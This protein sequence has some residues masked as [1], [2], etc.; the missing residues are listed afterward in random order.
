MFKLIYIDT[1]IIIFAITQLQFWFGVC[2]EA[3][4]GVAWLG[5]NPLTNK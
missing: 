4:V 1:Y 2:A 5:H 3:E